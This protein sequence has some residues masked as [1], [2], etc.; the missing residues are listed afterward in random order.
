MDEE[1]EEQ[2]QEQ[3]KQSMPGQVAKQGM[4]MAKQ[5]AVNAVKKKGKEAAVK[6]GAKIAAFVVANA[7]TIA[8][9]VAIIAAVCFVSFVILPAIEDFIDQLLAEDVD[10][11]TYKTVEEYCT[12]DETRS[13]YG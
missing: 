8:I 1:R 11:V 10:E 6:M 2:G 9:I 7:L 12:I 5:E 13:P 4:N 3:Q